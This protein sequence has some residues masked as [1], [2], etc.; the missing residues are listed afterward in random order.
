MQTQ[1]SLCIALD[2]SDRRW[3]LETAR[4][5]AHHTGWLKIGLEAFVAHGPG[6]VSEVADLGP[7]IFLDLNPFMYHKGRVTTIINYQLWAFSFTEIKS[8]LRTPPILF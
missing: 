5:L 1:D 3:I 4:K 6:L 7:R 8:F 2:G